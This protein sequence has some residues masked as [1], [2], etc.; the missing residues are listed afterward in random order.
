MWG[1][2]ARFGRRGMP[3]PFAVTRR[4]GCLSNRIDGSMPRS[5]LCWIDRCEERR[6]SVRDRSGCP[7]QREPPN[8]PT[9]RSRR[10]MPPTSLWSGPKNRP[11]TEPALSRTR[12]CPRTIEISRHRR[13]VRA[14][15][16]ASRMPVSA[17]STSGRAKSSVAISASPSTR[18][19]AGP[20]QGA[21]RLRHPGAQGS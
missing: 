6:G 10:K 2:S 20:V 9:S 7:L 8:A 21:G 12:K 17:T 16:P 13:S 4:R 18:S 11:S 14:R 19:P 15:P 1:A 3:N 5:G